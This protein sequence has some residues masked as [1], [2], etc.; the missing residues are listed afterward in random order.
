MD[1]FDTVKKSFIKTFIAEDRY[2]M[3][4][5]GLGNTLK[6]ALFA[7]LMG[8][9]IGMIVAVIKVSCK[10]STRPNIILKFLNAVC[11]LYT[12]VI[13]GTPV[14]VQLL[15]F[16]NVIFVSSDAAVL[17]G[18]LTFG[19]NSGAYVAEIIRAGIL[20]V[21][22]GQTE[23]GRSLGL[24][25]STTMMTIIMPQALKNILPA[26]GNEFISILKETSVIG[27][28]GV[29]DITRFAE[30]VITR[31]A[32]VYFPY[33]SIALVYLVMVMALN[34]LVKKLE[35]RLAKSDRS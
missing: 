12:T 27:F 4:L 6:V 30:K 11:E 5:E 22:V 35:K 3:L 20:A 1:F 29:M 18:T 24:S 17:I 10:Q 16:Y 25:Q 2:K 23:A 19:I 34:Y 28:L 26:I 8:V 13:R 7:T 31:T 32:D 9:V 15:I 33:L 21:D 14:V